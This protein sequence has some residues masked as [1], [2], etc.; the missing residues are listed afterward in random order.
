MYRL[1]IYLMYVNIRTFLIFCCVLSIAI[2]KIISQN[3]ISNLGNEFL[4]VGPLALQDN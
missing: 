1:G 3:G 2:I 4:F